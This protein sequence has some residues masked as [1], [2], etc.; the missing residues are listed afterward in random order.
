MYYNVITYFIAD[1][2][3]II[4]IITFSLCNAVFFCSVKIIYTIIFT[5]NILKLECSMSE[6]VIS[7]SSLVTVHFFDFSLSYSVA[8]TFLSPSRSFAR[9]LHGQNLLSVVNQLCKE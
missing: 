4:I 8:I 1:L 3:G 2:N 9:A 6:C 7:S 5:I